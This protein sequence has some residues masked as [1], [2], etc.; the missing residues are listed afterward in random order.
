MQSSSFWHQNFTSGFCRLLFSSFTPNFT[1]SLQNLSLLHYWASQVLTP[2]PSFKRDL[3]RLVASPMVIFRD[4]I[5]RRQ[6]RLHCRP[7]K[8]VNLNRY[9]KEMNDNDPL[10]PIILLKSFPVVPTQLDVIDR[11]Q[12]ITIKR[13]RQLYFKWLPYAVVTPLRKAASYEPRI[14]IWGIWVIRG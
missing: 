11:I 6:W 10:S 2:F 12:M 8:S 3:R 14:A 7:S 9:Q 13:H 5:V 4:T 1:H